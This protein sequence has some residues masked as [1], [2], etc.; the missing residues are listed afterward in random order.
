[1]VLKLWDL[2]FRS[3]RAQDPRKVT[4]AERPSYSPPKGGSHCTMRRLSMG[5]DGL[6]NVNFM[7]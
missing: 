7:K 3:L 4:L 2:S 1:M 6:Y 5:F